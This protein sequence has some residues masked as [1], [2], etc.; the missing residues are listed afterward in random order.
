[1][2]AR[3]R[4]SCLPKRSDFSGEPD[5]N[6]CIPRIAGCNYHR[7]MA[8]SAPQRARRGRLI[9]AAV[10]SLI[11]LNFATASFALDHITYKRNGK[12]ASIDGKVLLTATDGGMMLLSADG[13]IYNIVPEE[14]VSHKEDG[15]PFVP[16][17][18]AELRQHLLAELP[19]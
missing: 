1:M 2:P 10:A 3:A 14:L 9:L 7:W 16:L 11:I 15:D 19:A 13:Q 18:G 8:T 6:F 5:G 17:T 4:S 12:T